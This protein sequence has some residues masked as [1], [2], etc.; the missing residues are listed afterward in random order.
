MRCYACKQFCTHKGTGINTDP[1]FDN[2][3]L[4]KY[5][6]KHIIR[7]FKKRKI[8]LS[9]KKNIWD[10]DLADMKLINKYK[11]GI[12]LWYDIFEIFLVNMHGLF[13]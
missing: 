8:C 1:P 10:V 9:L 6:Q 3:Q 7:K 13:L 2:Q 4:E 11:K 5:L 12:Q